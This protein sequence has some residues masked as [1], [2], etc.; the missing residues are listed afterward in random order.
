MM[1]L[2]LSTSSM[3]PS[4]ECTLYVL[5]VITVIIITI[6]IHFLLELKITL[7]S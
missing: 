2:I 7:Y 3:V 6:I 1:T 5:A 4:I